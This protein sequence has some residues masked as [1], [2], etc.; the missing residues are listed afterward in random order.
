MLN[1]PLANVLSNIQNLEKVGKTRCLA[2]PSS[3]IIEKVLTIMKKNGYVKEFKVINDGKGGVIEIILT[4]KI[5]KCG[6]IK[7]RY[8]VKKDGYEKFEKRYLLAKDFGIIIVS[9]P[10]GIMTH[11][12]A[13]EKNFGG[14]LLAYIY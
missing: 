9:T 4:G 14:R 7:P 13:K 2:K 12:E 6:A 11:L 5:N 3:K 1:D 8:N 10:K